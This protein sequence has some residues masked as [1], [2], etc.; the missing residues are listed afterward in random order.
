M[1]A[2]GGH[3]FAGELGR[4][5]PPPLELV[6]PVAARALAALATHAALGP[7]SSPTPTRLAQAQGEAMDSTAQAA[8]SAYLNRLLQPE[9][10]LGL[11]SDQAP[12]GEPENRDDRDDAA[13][14]TSIQLLNRLFNIG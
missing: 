8:A 3:V 7:S 14:S 13:R 9:G 5:A 6:G 11:A 4:S 2:G 12:S 10:P 1:D